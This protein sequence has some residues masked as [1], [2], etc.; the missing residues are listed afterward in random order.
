MI[1]ENIKQQLRNRFTYNEFRDI[2]LT[3]IKLPIAFCEYETYRLDL[4][5][6]I[7]NTTSYYV[8]NEN[9]P[10]SCLLSPPTF[11]YNIDCYYY[12]YKK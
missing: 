2:N 8:N 5:G 12:T 4:I 11:I 10:N 9:N 1:I 7:I 3:N 6:G